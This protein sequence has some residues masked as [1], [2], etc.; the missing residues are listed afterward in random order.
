MHILYIIVHYLVKCN[1]CNQTTRSPTNSIFLKK[2]KTDFQKRFL[3][4]ELVETFNY[5]LGGKFKTSNM[6]KSLK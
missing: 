3:K 1:N 5:F 2:E 6:L 4:I